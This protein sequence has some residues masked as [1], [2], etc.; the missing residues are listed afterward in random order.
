MKTKLLAAAMAVGLAF[1]GFAMAQEVKPLPGDAPT[2]TQT[3]AAPPI[4][5]VKEGQR[6]ERSY[7]QQPPL[8][9]H[10]IEKYEIDV[11]VNMCLRCHDWPN[12]VQ[13][14]APLISATH[15]IDRDGT[16]LDHV[17][18]RRWF[19]VQCHVP[20]ADAKPL[21]DNKFQSAVGGRP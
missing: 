8:I 4:F 6:Y 9:P 16:K 2:T 11:K 17:S 10:R 20:Q 14:N 13:E 19:C 21:V 15:F 12:N 18:S 5:D 1:G 3:N 7:L